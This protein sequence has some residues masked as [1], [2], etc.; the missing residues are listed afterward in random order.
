ME[1]KRLSEKGTGPLNSRR[2]S[3]FIG[4][5][6]RVLSPFLIASKMWS[7]KRMFPVTPSGSQ[8]F[9]LYPLPLLPSFPSFL[10]VPQAHAGPTKERI[11]H[12]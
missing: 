10:H 4:A 12:A 1:C 8:R 3:L 6:S 5:N 2:K 11:D 9:S 7:T